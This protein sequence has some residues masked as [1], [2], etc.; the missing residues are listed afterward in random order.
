MATLRDYSDVFRQLEACQARYVVVGSLAVV[1]HGYARPVA[2]LD[3]VIDGAPVESDRVLRALQACGFMPSL[4][5][6]LSLLSVARM[7][8]SRGL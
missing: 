7:L 8:D 3:L 5:L 6:P 4:P 2:D 1:L